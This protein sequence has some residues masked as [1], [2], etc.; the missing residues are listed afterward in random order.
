MRLSRPLGTAR[1]SLKD[2]SPA[3]LLHSA[4][5][6]LPVAHPS[7]ASAM[8]DFGGSR[9]LAELCR[10]MARSGASRTMYG[11]PT[12]RKDASTRAALGEA[13]RP[14]ASGTAKRPGAA[15]TS[16]VLGGTDRGRCSGRLTARCN[17]VLANTHSR[18]AS[19]LH[20]DPA[21]HTQ[22]DQSFVPTFFVRG[23]GVMA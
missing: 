10:Q 12:I 8:T 7:G 4:R 21:T 20:A 18:T 22:G 16:V 9:A 19:K 6:A 1:R 14:T 23:G 15:A 5:Y 2:S 3:P 17:T 11:P 13:S